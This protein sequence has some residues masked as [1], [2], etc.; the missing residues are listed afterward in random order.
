MPGR[1]VVGEVRGSGSPGI[2]LNEEVMA[3]RADM[4]L[5]LASWSDLVAE[6]RAVPPPDRT[7]PAMARF[8][9][10]QLPWLAE[11]PAAGDVAD[12]VAV[13]TRSASTAGRPS[14][15][16]RIRLGDCVVPECPGRLVAL[17]RDR[18][19]AVPSAITCDTSAGHTW[20]PQLWHTLGGRAGAAGSAGLSAEDVATTWRI[21]RGSVYWLASAHGWRR[22][23][24]GRR[25]L[26]ALADVVTTLAAGRDGAA[27]DPGGRA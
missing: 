9:A 8:L 21:P 6:T 22:Q 10:G 3:T 16:H 15:W 20:P 1:A 17:V 26:Y 11:H 7:V 23:R 25:V 13:L 27:D 18:D 19:G 4:R 12:E 24:H 2:R 14:P 5:V